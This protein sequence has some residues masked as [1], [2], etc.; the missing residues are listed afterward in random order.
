MFLESHI[1]FFKRTLRCVNSHGD[2]RMEVWPLIMVSMKEIWLK[3]RKA[4]DYILHFRFY[5]PLCWK[6]KHQH[7]YTELR[8]KANTKAYYSL[9]PFNLKYNI[10]D[11]D[12]IYKVD[13]GLIIFEC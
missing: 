10:V 12:K 1:I 6:G 5:A 3:N 7:S 13:Y 4:R 8:L 9:I 11:V 2:G